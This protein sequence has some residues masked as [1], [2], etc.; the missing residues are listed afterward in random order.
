[1]ETVTPQ[2]ALLPYVE[3]APTIP[4]RASI[5]WL[6]GLGADGF[7]LAD[8]VPQV[9]LPSHLGVRS[10]F[11]HAPVRPITLNKGFPMRGWYDILGL[12][13]HS[14][15]DEQGIYEAEQSIHALIAHEESRGI[16]AHRIILMGF[17][18]GGALA[19]YSALR[20][21]KRLGGV[22]AL[23]AYLPIALT[24]PTTASPANKSLPILIAHGTNDM[25]VPYEFGQYAREALEKLDY[26]VKWLEYPMEHNIC[27]AEIQDISKWLQQ[28]LEQADS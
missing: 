1:M 18:Q 15:E 16:P 4:A 19:L 26:T 10:L 22:A 12:D 28:L 21:P 27:S 13:K 8:I 17:S 11:P 14:F 5:I 3:I 7:D 20:Y 2:S 25:L 24:L 9:N 6:H 23:S